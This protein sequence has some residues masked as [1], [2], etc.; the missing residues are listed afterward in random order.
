MVNIIHA[1]RNTPQITC[2]VSPRGTLAFLRAAQGYALVCG[3]D[4]VTPEDIKYVA[5]PVLAHRLT[6][7]V[8]FDAASAAKQ[9]V[10]NILSSV[11][12]PTEDWTRR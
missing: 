4:F 3:R 9:A 1:T 11:T 10:S 12:V 8:S 7:N 2:G 6:M 5:V